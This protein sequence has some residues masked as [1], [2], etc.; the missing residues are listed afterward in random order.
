MLE[1]HKKLE[2]NSILLLIFAVIAVSIGGIVEIV[3][4]F[5][6]QTTIE[7]VKGVRPL[8]PL[9]LAGED[10]YVREGCNVCHSQQIRPLRDEVQRYGHYSLAA[11][12]MYDHPFVWGSERTGPDLARVGGKYS[13]E[14]HVEHLSNPR[15]VVPESIMPRYDFLAR[16]GLRTWDLADKMRALRTTGVPYTDDMINNAQQDAQIQTMPDE[17]ASEL[18]KRYGD[19]VIPQDFGS[20]DPGSPSEMDALVAYLQQLGT[21][22]DFTTYDP[23]YEL[24]AAHR[25]A[26]K[27]ATQQPA[28]EK[29]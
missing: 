22:V 28:K 5:R 25:T 23:D 20:H 2:R 14:W 21:Q 27:P 16:R 7:P 15:S 17:D 13:N 4:L 29:K 6:M 12:S 8:T 10:I 11:E 18:Q 1:S 9:E 3:P 24:H 26:T 19:K